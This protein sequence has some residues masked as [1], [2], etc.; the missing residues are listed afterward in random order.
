MSFEKKLTLS[1]QHHN[2]WEGVRYAEYTNIEILA[3]FE[4]R[5]TTISPSNM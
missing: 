4:R 3:V 1:V 5:P 2:N